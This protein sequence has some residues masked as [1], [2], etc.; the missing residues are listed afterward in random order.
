MAA[1][2]YL[3]NDGA[4]VSIQHARVEHENVQ[5]DLEGEASLSALQDPWPLTLTMQAQARGLTADSLL[6]ADRYIANLPRPAGAD[7]EPSAQADG[8]TDARSQPGEAVD[9]DTDT[10]TDTAKTGAGAAA[11]DAANTAAA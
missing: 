11:V 2:A 10:D 1:D 6:C 5:A 4:Q 9:T 7:I 8:K 3:T